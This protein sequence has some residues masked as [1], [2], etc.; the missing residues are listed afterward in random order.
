MLNTQARDASGENLARL[1]SLPDAALVTTHEAAEVLC[2]KSNTLSWCRCHGGGP[3]YLRVGK[4][5]IR[6]R[7]ADLRAYMKGA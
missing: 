6:Y 1:L 4:K 3:E 5:S 2:L 7:M